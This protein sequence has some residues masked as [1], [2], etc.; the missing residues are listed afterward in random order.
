MRLDQGLFKVPLVGRGY[1]IVV[2]IRCVRTLCLLLQGG[3]GL[4]EAMAL[5]GRSSGSSWVASLMEVEAESVRHGSTLADAIRRIPPLAGSLP[6]WIQAGEAS[7]AL[8]RLLDTAGTAYQHQWNRYI[9]RTLSWLEPALIL[10]IGLFV[11]LVTLSV[12]LP[13]MSLNPVIP[14]SG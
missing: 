11:L 4:V 6:S 2:N 7:G 5:S 8:E 14:A 10:C 9:S 12:L 3:V 13:I 1:V